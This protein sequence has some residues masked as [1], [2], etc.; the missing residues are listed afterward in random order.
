MVIFKMERSL[1]E[2]ANHI[3]WNDMHAHNNKL[4]FIELD[5]N[6]KAMYSTVSMWILAVE[7]ERKFWMYLPSEHCIR[8]SMLLEPGGQPMF[9]PNNSSL[10]NLKVRFLTES[11]TTT[12]TATTSNAIR[13]FRIPCGSFLSFVPPLPVENP[14]Y[15]LSYWNQALFLKNVVFGW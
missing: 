3:K 13:V 9:F 4:F 5:W 11:D 14:C 8:H 12:K 2:K 15:F 10:L 1:F 7:L 6:L